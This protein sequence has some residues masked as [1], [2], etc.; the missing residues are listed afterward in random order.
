MKSEQ[1]QMSPI[2]RLR[3]RNITR[4]DFWD[5]AQRPTRNDVKKYIEPESNSQSTD[6]AE[7]ETETFDS[8]L[9]SEDS[10]QG[11]PLTCSRSPIRNLTKSQQSTPKQG[12]TVR[13]PRQMICRHCQH[14]EEIV[15]FGLLCGECGLSLCPKCEQCSTC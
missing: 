9:C 12:V 6:E 2:Y 8:E 1:K 5:K 14:S 15:D 10:E 3:E 4:K 7:T 11:I 13:C